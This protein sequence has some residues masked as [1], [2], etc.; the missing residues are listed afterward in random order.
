MN[1]NCADLSAHSVATSP[2]VAEVLPQ[3][4][5]PAIRRWTALPCS[6]CQIAGPSC[7][8]PMR[9][10]V[11]RHST[12]PSGSENRTRTS[13]KSARLLGVTRHDRA[14]KHAAND[15][16]AFFTWSVVNPRGTFTTALK[17]SAEV[18]TFNTTRL[19]S[20]ARSPQSHPWATKQR[21]RLATS[22]RRSASCQRTA[23]RGVARTPT[24]AKAESRKGQ[25]D[26][27]HGPT[28]FTNE[29]TIKPTSSEATPTAIVM[30]RRFAHT[31]RASGRCVTAATISP[32][33]S[34]WGPSSAIVNVG[35]RC[36]RRRRQSDR[37]IRGLRRLLPMQ[38]T[39]VG[40][41][42]TSQSHPSDCSR[43]CDNRA[44]Q[45]RQLLLQRG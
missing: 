3:P 32:L 33:V 11:S 25:N 30:V 26:K 37:S 24:T 1:A 31:S 29:E 15:V 4:V 34:H 10:G 16:S 20:S 41:Q 6:G 8:S 5:G 27:S 23:P 18:V 21:A 22:S 36:A 14:S 35:Q 44:R 13:H 38:W 12:A 28:A 45:N 42:Q 9:P 19:R 2:S 43:V 40:S 7:V 17:P 39:R